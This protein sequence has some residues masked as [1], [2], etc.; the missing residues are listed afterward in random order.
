M[1]LSRLLLAVG[2]AIAVLLNGCGKSSNDSANVRALNLIS[3]ATG[4]NIEAGGSTIL[5][6]GT[7]ESLSG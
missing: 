7:F 5:A 2:C 4:V 1:S 3:G 6:N